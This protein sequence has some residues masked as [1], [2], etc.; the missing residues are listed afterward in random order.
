VRIKSPKLDGTS[1]SWCKLEVNVDDPKA[2][3]KA[4]DQP[5]A[6]TVSTMTVQMKTVVNPKTHAHEVVAVAAALHRGVQ[7]DRATDENR[8]DMKWFIAVRP[9]GTSVGPHGAARL[10]HDLKDVLG[11][12]NMGAVVTLPNE[13]ALLSM[14]LTRIGAEDPD[15]LVSHNLFGFDFDV[16]LSRSIEHK[17]G[18]WSKLGRLRKSKMP[19]MK[20]RAGSNREA[21]IAGASTGRILADTYLSARDLLREENYSLAHL[22]KNY[23]KVPGERPDIDPM[24]VPAYF[25]SSQHLTQLIS[26]MATGA[27]LVQKLLFK[28]QVLPL[29][30]QLTNI[31]GN[32]WASTAKGGDR[33]KRIE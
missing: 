23:L 4:P 22:A 1:A 16:L 6:P 31:S 3:A 29:T 27:G 7:L 2:L 28:L 26:H 30:K 10:P 19:N 33:A 32:L 15:V 18:L 9:L 14:L 13:R 21:L 8:R 17:L 20:G 11:A 24:D 12:S 25:S 5:P